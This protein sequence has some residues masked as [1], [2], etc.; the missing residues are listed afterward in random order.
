MMLLRNAR[1]IDPASGHDGPG[2]VRIRDGR[3]IEIAEDLTAEDGERVQDLRGA[4]LAPALIDLRCWTKPGAG[5]KAGLDA[6]ARA[7]AA[8]GVGTLVLAPDS[9]DGL[10]RPEDFASIE[11]A[12]L[13]SPVRLLPSGLAVDADGEMGE[14]GLMLRAGAALIGDGGAAIADTRLARRILA[15]AST[16]DAWVSVRAEDPHLA[17]GTCAHESDLA[18]RLGLPARPGA[19]ERLAIERGA[20]LCELTG[21]RLI[22]DRITTADAVSALAAARARGLELAVTAP[23]T[24]LLFN[25]VDAGGFDARFRLEPPLR[26]ESDRLALIAALADGD[27]DAVVSDHRAATGEAKA[28]PFPEAEAGSAN[29]EA[30]LPALCTL[31]ADGRLSL[32]DALRPVTS[33]PADLLG[34]DQ[35]R[36]EPGAPADLVVFD[37]EAPTVYGRAGLFCDASSAFENRRLFGKV[38]I[39]IVEGAIIHQPEG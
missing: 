9:G 10:S 30:L 37:P 38:L 6:T 16:F 31:A 13:T 17:R 25:E 5:G 33:G 23:V 39:T 18:M 8:G 15:Y 28:H 1:L 36:L 4:A 11:T 22:F 3:I 14:I 7:A 34:L 20:A 19:G 26:S 24:H 32:V 12:A 21:A 29:L 27:I 2:D 35:G